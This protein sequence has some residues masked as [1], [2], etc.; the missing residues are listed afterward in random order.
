MWTTQKGVSP[1]TRK[2]PFY[3][4]KGKVKLMPEDLMLGRH[5]QIAD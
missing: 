1:E 5:V 3:E 4:V 2:M